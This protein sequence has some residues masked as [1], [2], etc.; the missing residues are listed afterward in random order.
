M[1]NFGDM[2]A[3]RYFQRREDY[4]PRHTPGDSPFRKFTV[5]C[6]NCGSYKLR[7]ES[8]F[9]SDAGELAVELFCTCCRQRERLPLK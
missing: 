4:Q 3:A 9:D 6:L 8:H 1:C 5:Q 2:N 7:L